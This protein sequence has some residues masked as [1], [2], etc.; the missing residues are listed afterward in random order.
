M[1]PTFIMDD[2]VKLAAAT[3][4]RPEARLNLRE[5]SMANY[6]K[7]LINFA[8]TIPRSDIRCVCINFT[9]SM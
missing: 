8:K 4:P 3:D 9:K 6:T 2:R 7:P 5:I 1:V